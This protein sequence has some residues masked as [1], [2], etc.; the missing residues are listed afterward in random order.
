MDVHPPK[1]VSIGIDPYPHFRVDHHFPYKHGHESWWFFTFS[2]T[3]I[4]N[5][6][7]IDRIW[8]CSFPFSHIFPYLFPILDFHFFPIEWGFLWY[9]MT[10]PY[11]NSRTRHP[12]HFYRPGDTVQFKVKLSRSSS[13]WCVL[14]RVA[15]WVAGGWWDDDCSDE[16]DHS[17][18]FPTKHQ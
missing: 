8:N 9:F 10:C 11:S 3:P 5:H 1:N 17:G 6:P 15:G 13:Q 12:C 4:H 2:D 7:E 14:R 18:K 16:M